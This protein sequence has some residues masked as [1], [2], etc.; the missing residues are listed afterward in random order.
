MD[1]T[2]PVSPEGHPEDPP[3]TALVSDARA[4][5]TEDRTTAFIS[6]FGPEGEVVASCE[7]ALLAETADIHGNWRG[8]LAG[9]A[10]TLT[11]AGEV[12]LG[13]PEDVATAEARDDDETDVTE[14]P[15]S[16]DEYEIVYE[17]GDEGAPTVER[18][19][20]ALPVIQWQTPKHYH[21]TRRALEH[22]ETA[23]RKLAKSVEDAKYSTEAR[24][25]RGDAMVIREQ[26]LPAFREQGELELVGAEELASAVCNA[27]RDVVRKHA[28]PSTELVDHEAVL[29]NELGERVATFAV[30][31]AER[32]FHAG[33]MVRSAMTPG[34]L[35]LAAI[36]SLGEVSNSTS[37]T[38][39]EKRK[40]DNDDTRPSDQGSTGRRYR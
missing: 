18:V 20:L 7:V 23:L 17:I 19:A 36:K 10:W 16:E 12:I 6:L 2:K 9:L 38:P 15:G 22:E 35:S 5:I 30:D 28:K 1:E 26:L 29:L 34:A 37:L 3:T 31:V 11:S 32:A 14:L 24:S 21:L 4:V 25:I 8:E 40:N 13:T 33:T 27:I 39:T